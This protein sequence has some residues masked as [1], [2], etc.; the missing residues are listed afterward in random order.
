MRT[1]TNVRG[2]HAWSIK[3]LKRLNDIACFKIEISSLTM[4]LHWVHSTRLYQSRESLPKIEKENI[5]ERKK[6]N[7]RDREEE[8]YDK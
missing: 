3:K 7:L 8:G 5:K 6:M 1:K 2:L 4:P